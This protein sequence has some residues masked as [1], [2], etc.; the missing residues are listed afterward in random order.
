M[1]MT[2][3]RPSSSTT[4]S[5]TSP[6]K[7]EPAIENLPLDIEGLANKNDNELV[8]LAGKTALKVFCAHY[9]VEMGGLNL[10]V[11]PWKSMHEKLATSRY[12]LV[13]YPPNVSLPWSHDTRKGIENLTK[14]EL[15]SLLRS[16]SDSGVPNKLTVIKVDDHTLLNNSKVPLITTAPDPHGNTCQYFL[17]DVP[18]KPKSGLRSKK[19]KKGKAAKSR[20][21]RSKVVRFDEDEL[22]SELSVDSDSEIEEIR[23]SK[24]G[25]TTFDCFYSLR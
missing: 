18:P 19:D 9:V 25:K 1:S 14:P 20:Q 15:I 11:F 13:N 4:T 8:G 10:K 23:T 12:R 3:S 24:P 17:R 21:T 7:L 6:V 5:T 2:P 16:C 22:Y